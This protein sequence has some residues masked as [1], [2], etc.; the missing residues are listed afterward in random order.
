MSQTPENSNIPNI[1]PI[2]GPRF[3]RC[4]PRE[5]SSRQ[6]VKDVDGMSNS[7][8]PH[9][10]WHLHL[11]QISSSHFHH[12]TVSPFHHAI[13]LWCVWGCKMP[14]DTSFLTIYLNSLDMNSPPLSVLRICILPLSLFSTIARNFLKAH[15]ASSLLLSM[16]THI[17]LL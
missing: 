6:S 16:Y 4:L 5:G 12:R 15:N 1:W 11:L 2:S 3:V 7:F 8:S 9:Y 17:I 10:R 13:V 14:S